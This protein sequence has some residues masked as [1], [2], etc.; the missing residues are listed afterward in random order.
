MQKLFRNSDAKAVATTTT[1]EHC[2]Q[3]HDK[4][5]FSQRRRKK[6]KIL[7][8]NMVNSYAAEELSHKTQNCLH[9]RM[10]IPTTP[11]DFSHMRSERM[12]SQS[13]S[14][15][16]ICQPINIRADVGTEKNKRCT[17]DAQVNVNANCNL[18]FIF[19]LFSFRRVGWMVFMIDFCIE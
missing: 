13:C 11:V 12:L 1:W 5:F 14:C 18:Q 15:R 10:W 6:R 3:T 19:R 2:V 4:D 16:W 7:M 17:D 9:L 8:K